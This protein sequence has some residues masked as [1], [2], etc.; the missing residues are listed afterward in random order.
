MNAIIEKPAHSVT[1]QEVLDQQAEQALALKSARDTRAIMRK[2]FVALAVGLGGFGLWAS[3]APLD[4]GV[5][6]HGMVAIDTKRKAVQH[7][8]GG[9]VKDVLVREGQHVQADQVLMRL[10]EASARANFESVRQ[11][12]LGLNATRT[13]LLAEQMG[14]S[15][16][17][18]DPQVLEAASQDPALAQQLQVQ[19]SL[20]QTRRQALQ[21]ELA[22]YEEAIAGAKAQQESARAIQVQREQQLGLLR[23]ELT[24]LTDLVREG[25]APRTRQMEMERHASEVQAGLADLAGQIIRAG[26]SVAELTLRLQS[27]RSEYA[28]EVETQLVDVSRELQTE[29]ER[30][31]AQQAD[32][33]RIEIR[34][35]AA[36][37]VVGLTVQSEGAVV[38]SGQKLMEIV[39]DDQDLLL[40]TR[41]PAHLID[42]VQSGLVAKARFNTFAHSPQLVVPARVVSVSGDLLTDPQMPQAP[43]YLARL[44]LTPEGLRTLGARQ[45]QPGMPVEV[46][47]VTGERSLLTYWLH[48]LTKRLAGA[49]KE[50]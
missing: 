23:E 37:Q 49:M 34:A 21:S 48:P 20:F 28:K 15:K 50:E 42:K 31:K 33:K 8:S 17:I 39:P 30:F 7:P 9:I 18:F 35:P 16:L 45:L 41:V 5:P 6:T 1:A 24:G 3:L 40:E 43:Y 2:G 12:Y 14:Q 10:D 44:A 19:R 36:G 22:S 32:L 47:I 29:A 27:R 13:R 26:R 4:E 11:R 46:V 25:Y 38:Q